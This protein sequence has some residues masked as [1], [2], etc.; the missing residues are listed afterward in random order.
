VSAFSKKKREPK[1]L[2]ANSNSGCCWDGHWGKMCSFAD[3]DYAQIL[4]AGLA[5]YGLSDGDDHFWTG[6][7]LPLVFDDDGDVEIILCNHLN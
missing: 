7:E 2:K 1:L 4:Q 6:I 5:V 3:M